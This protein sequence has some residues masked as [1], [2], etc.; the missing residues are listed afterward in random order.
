MEVVASRLSLVQRANEPT[1]EA[2]PP[3][4]A[5]PVAK[6]FSI[7]LG[8]WREDEF[9][10]DNHSGEE[11]DRLAADL[12]DLTASWERGEIRWGL[13]QIAIQRARRDPT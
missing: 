3:I 9:V 1:P 10:W 2:V 7:N 13:R 5:P 11:L 8:T 12:S 4:S 6:M